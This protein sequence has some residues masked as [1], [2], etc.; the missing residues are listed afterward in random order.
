MQLLCPMPGCQSHTPTA[1]KLVAHLV[2]HLVSTHLVG[3]L[4]STHLVGHLV[5]T[6]LVGLSGS[7]SRKHLE[8]HLERSPPGKVLLLPR[9]YAQNGRAQAPAGICTGICGP[10]PQAAHAGRWSCESLHAFPRQEE[11]E[12]HFHTFSRFFLSPCARA[13]HPQKPLHPDNDLAHLLYARAKDLDS[14]GRAGA[15]AAKQPFL[16]AGP[17]KQVKH[18]HHVRRGLPG[19]GEPH[20]S[21]MVIRGDE[22]IKPFYVKHPSKEQHA[23]R[24]KQLQQP[25]L[26]PRPKPQP[27]QTER[28]EPLLRDG[29]AAVA[30]AGACRMWCPFP[31]CCTAPVAASS[32]EQPVHTIQLP[33]TSNLNRPMRSFQNPEELEAHAFAAHR[34][35]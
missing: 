2:G 4:V 13:A 33:T 27:S 17:S 14:V 31:R 7:C 28:P 16:A 21:Y 32:L 19:A 34:C 3:H 22:G 30:R 23:P 24:S 25:Q 12:G 8:D 15:A 26:Q 20:M 9:L 5:S 35:G 18:G 6:H 29:L 10:F 1:V 11:H